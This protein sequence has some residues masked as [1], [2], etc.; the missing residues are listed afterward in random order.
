MN[1]VT[2]TSTPNLWSTPNPSYGPGTNPGSLF[3]IY[4]AGNASN[5]DTITYASVIGNTSEGTYAYTI[6]NIS[7]TQAYANILCAGNDCNVAR[8]RPSLS[9]PQQA[10][11]LRIESVGTILNAWASSTITDNPPD[12]PQIKTSPSSQ[13]VVE[14][15]L[16]DPETASHDPFCS[17]LPFDPHAETAC[18]G[19]CYSC[20][21]AST[22]AIP[23]FEQ[24]FTAMFNALYQSGYS[25]SMYAARMPTAFPAESQFNF[26]KRNSVVG[27]VRY[28]RLVY[29]CDWAWLGVLLACTLVAVVVILVGS[30][31]QTQILGPDILGYVSTLTRDND[32]TP[33]PEG[34]NLLDGMDRTLLLKDVKVRIHDVRPDAMV[35]HVTLSSVDGT[36]LQPGR[37]YV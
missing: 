28:W 7:L 30:Y 13:T 24:R 36:K 27:E 1:R 26:G 22:V 23:V 21:D 17:E 6:C 32:S 9:A 14:K 29:L 37:R 15:W 34:G 19:D 11:L 25:A 31:L 5:A 33:L 3:L 2:A 4:A 20:P 8:M 16:F 12:G 10:P 18:D 35:G